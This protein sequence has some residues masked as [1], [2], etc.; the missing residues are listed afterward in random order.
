MKK[1]Q[2]YNR[3][4]KEKRYYYKNQIF[5]KKLCKKNFFPNLIK[6]WPSVIIGLAIKY[7]FL[8]GKMNELVATIRHV[9]N[10]FRVQTLSTF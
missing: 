8:H 10:Q 6:I 3:P 1:Q 2:F 7:A 9:Q 4:Y 5:D